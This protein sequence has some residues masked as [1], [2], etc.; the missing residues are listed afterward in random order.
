MAKKTH[1]EFIK[2][3]YEKN[4]N[5]ENIEI[6]NKYTGAKELIKCKCKIDGYEWEAR[7]DSLLRKSGCQKCY[8]SRRGN[9]LKSTHE[10]FM[11]KFYKKNKNSNNIEILGK[12]NN[13]KT[14]IKTI[15]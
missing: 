11:R 5:A 3:F 2:E 7:A 9:T 4:P 8:D 12:Y 1:E 15:L 13:N 6:L 10:D 14:P